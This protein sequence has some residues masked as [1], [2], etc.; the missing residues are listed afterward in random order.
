MSR[1]SLSGS[2]VVA[3]AVSVGSGVSAVR[4]MA[5]MVGALTR[6]STAPLTS[7]GASI[8][9]R[10]PRALSRTSGSAWASVITPSSIRRWR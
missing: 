8:I 10:P 9:P 7:M 6:A 5:A 4:T 3:P 2:G 1:S